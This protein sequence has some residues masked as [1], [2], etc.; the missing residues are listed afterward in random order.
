M[1]PFGGHVP[2]RFS[3]GHRHCQPQR[4][5]GLAHLGGARQDM[6][7]LGEQAV[8]HKVWWTQGL[9]HQGRPIDRVEFHVTSASLS[10][11]LSVGFIT[12]LC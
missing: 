10:A 11:I 8:H 9:A 5:P 6:Q 2:D 12:R 4:Q 7:P 3:L 1:A